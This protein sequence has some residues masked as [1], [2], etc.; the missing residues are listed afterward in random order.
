MHGYAPIISSHVKRLVAV[1]RVSDAC[2]GREG[3]ITAL[4]GYAGG[5]KA[6]PLERRLVRFVFAVVSLSHHRTV[7]G[8]VGEHMTIWEEGEQQD[9]SCNRKDARFHTV[10]ISCRLLLRCKPRCLSNCCQLWWHVMNNIPALY[11]ICYFVFRNYC[12]LLSQ[13]FLVSNR[14]DLDVCRQRLRFQCSCQSY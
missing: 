9:D 8:V 2:W 7:V 4:A 14:K 5:K 12:Q 3:D 1:E 6:G 10:F 11:Y 13:H